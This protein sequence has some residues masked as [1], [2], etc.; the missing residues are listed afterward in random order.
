MAAV[1]AGAS[2]YVLKEVRGSGLIDAIRQV[3]MGR[4]LIDP[5]VMEKMINQIRNPGGENDKLASLSDREREVLD[6][7]ADGQAAFVFV[8]G[9]WCLLRGRHHTNSASPYM[10]ISRSRDE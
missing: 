2:G 3:A 6:L 8:P 5:G 7:I 10:P 1:L 4:T 9:G